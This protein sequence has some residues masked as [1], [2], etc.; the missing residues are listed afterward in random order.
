MSFLGYDDG[1]DRHYLDF[2]ND[3]KHHLLSEGK[4]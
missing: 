1:G 4:E 2:V 3:F